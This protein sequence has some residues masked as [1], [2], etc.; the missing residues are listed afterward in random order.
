MPVT[1][2]LGATGDQTGIGN[3]AGRDIDTGRAVP[4]MGSC[5]VVARQGRCSSYATIDRAG[6]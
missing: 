6:A 2:T 4:S 1:R 5:A 3:I